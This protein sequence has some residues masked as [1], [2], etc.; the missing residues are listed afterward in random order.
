MKSFFS[1]SNEMSVILV[2]PCLGNEWYNVRKNTFNSF[3]KITNEKEKEKKK[4]KTLPT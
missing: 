2:T 4:Q 3:S 1:E